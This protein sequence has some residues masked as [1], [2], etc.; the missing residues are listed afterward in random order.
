MAEANATL[1]AKNG[2]DD[3]KVET[4]GAIAEYKE[5]QTEEHLP[6]DQAIREI[7]E[8]QPECGDM[9]MSYKERVAKQ[10]P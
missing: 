8:L 5:S 3:E 4:E 6:L 1:Q 7:T 2:M 10:E 9:S